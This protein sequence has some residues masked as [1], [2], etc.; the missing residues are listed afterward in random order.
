MRVLIS[1][2]LFLSLTSTENH[3]GSN[4]VPQRPATVVD[5]AQHPAGRDHFWVMTLGVILLVWYSGP[6][7]SETKVP[8]A[9]HPVSRPASHPVSLGST[10]R[11]ALQAAVNTEINP[12]TPYHFMEL[13]SGRE[14]RDQ[15]RS[16]EEQAAHRDQAKDLLRKP[17]SAARHVFQDDMKQF[18]REK[19]KEL[20]LAETFGQ[21]LG[22]L[23]VDLLP[24]GTATKALASE[25]DLPL[26]MS[27]SPLQPARLRV[28]LHQAT[29]DNASA[30]MLRDL[31]LTAHVS[32]R[33]NRL[34]GVWE[35]GNFQLSGTIKSG[36]TDG[37]S[38]QWRAGY[39]F[40]EH[41]IAEA[42]GNQRG[43]ALTI[44]FSNQF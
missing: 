2:P 31:R 14:E 6:V 16:L 25:S 1:A 37:E 3:S 5:R 27:W 19:G 42:H 33:E 9:S 28:D 21:T 13:S 41:A 15:A 17:Y 36:D 11:T 34:E 22:S 44:Q 29:R 43:A 4:W 24:P 7:R 23:G 40:S 10:L 35:R 12:E 39:R 32:P 20:P 18:L 26:K 38:T 8:V 30:S